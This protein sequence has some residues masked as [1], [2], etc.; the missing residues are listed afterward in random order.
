MGRRLRP[1][2]MEVKGRRKIQSLKKYCMTVRE[3]ISKRKDFRGKKYMIE[4]HG[5]V[6]RRTSTPH[7]NG[8]R[9][10]RIFFI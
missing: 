8:T 10:R 9:R 3:M 5:G 2:R 7:K 4:P 1:M 6:Y